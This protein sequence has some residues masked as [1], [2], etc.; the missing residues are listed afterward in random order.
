MASDDGL[1]YMRCE[2]K[3]YKIYNNKEWGRGNSSMSCFDKISSPLRYC[4][5][6]GLHMC[7]N[8]KWL[9]R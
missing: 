2:W 6:R 7:A 8:D 4:V 9:Y 1:Y 5:C 3:G